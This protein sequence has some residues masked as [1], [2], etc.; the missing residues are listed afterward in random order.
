MPLSAA[1]KQ[2]RYRERIRQDPERHQATLQKERQRWHARAK[3]NPPHLSLNWEREIRETSDA[4]GQKKQQEHRKPKAAEA[5]P[6]CQT[7]PN[8]PNADN[9]NPHPANDAIPRQ[10]LL[11]KR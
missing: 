10:V 6:L 2:R 4:T 3:T 11:C 1:E 5:G 9:L 8:S 7:P